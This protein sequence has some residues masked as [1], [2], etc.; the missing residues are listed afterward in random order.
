MTMLIKHVIHCQKSGLP[1][2]TLEVGT[3]AGALPYLSHWD[4]CIG[5]HP[6]FSLQTQKLLQFTKHEWTRLAQGAEDSEISEVESNT[7]RVAFLAVLHTLDCVRQDEPALPPLHVVTTTINK[8][9]SLAY[10]KWHLESERFSF[11]T[12]HL[13]RYNKNLDFSNLPDY[14]DLC[15]D[16]KKDYETKVREVDERAKVKAAE[17]AV[18]A[19]NNTWITPTSK[20]MM[21]RWI[22]ANLSAT[23]RK[24]DAEWMSAIFLGSALV[25]QA[26]VDENIEWMEEIIEG[27]CPA[28]T[29]VMFAVRKRIEEIWRIW[30]NHNEVFEIDL[31]DF[32][33]PS[34]KLLVNGVKQAAV[35]PGERPTLEGFGGVKSKFF[36]A[37]AKWQIAMQQWNR[38]NPS[39]N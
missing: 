22:E 24:E 31:A 36:V 15:F 2:G 23:H 37:D 32:A 28:G 20:R 3:T 27:D 12:L 38:E 13:S 17:E 35:H 10:W 11:P 19:L 29:G 25:I 8:L 26:Q 16:I 21:W 1:I 34:T 18:I 7:L 39:G 5:Y 30:K 33:D 4:K 14:L 9:F 6:V